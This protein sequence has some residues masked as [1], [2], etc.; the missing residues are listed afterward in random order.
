MTFTPCVFT[1][2]RHVE[3]L[4]DD[5]LV[6]DVSSYADHPYCTFS[7]M[8]VHGDI[9]VPGMSNETSDTVEGIWQGL[10]VIRGKTA[11]RLFRGKGQ[12][13]GGKPAGHFYG[14]KDR[15]LGIVEARQKIYLVAYEWM[16]ANRADPDLIA[17]FVKRAFEGT[18]QYF[19]DVGDN[20]DINNADAPLAHAAVLVQYINR[21][22]KQRLSQ[23]P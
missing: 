18:S 17:K 14:K 16:L 3:H 5:A 8:W 10:K 7:P 23:K 1:P 4:P 22:C 21:I 15:L 9:P 2:Y 12:K 11:T 19:H 6:Y 20:G 13:R